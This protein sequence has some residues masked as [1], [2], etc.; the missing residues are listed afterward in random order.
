M[1]SRTTLK[2]KPNFHVKG[3]VGDYYFLFSHQT[4]LKYK[5][6]LK[7]QV[8]EKIIIIILDKEEK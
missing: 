4:T 6:G 5:V 7:F 8:I 3:L 2:P 1:M